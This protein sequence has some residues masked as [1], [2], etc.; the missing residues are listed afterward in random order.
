M[1]T[2]FPAAVGEHQKSQAIIVLV[3]DQ[4]GLRNFSASS[5]LG[6]GRKHLDLGARP[7]DIAVPG[8]S[9]HEVLPWIVLFRI[10]GGPDQDDGSVL[11]A[12]EIADAIAVTDRDVVDVQ[13]RLRC[14]MIEQVLHGN[15]GDDDLALWQEGP[16]QSCIQD[17]SLTATPSIVRP[18]SCRLT[19]IAA[20]SSGTR[21]N[22]WRSLVV[23][24]MR[25]VLDK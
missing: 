6:D 1:R 8:P 16:P 18:F 10:T 14:L 15:R 9:H 3:E 4:D 22:P 17:P 7:Y 11:V 2:T 13:D 12:D 25:G 20:L 24:S 23:A 5:S 21:A 19:S